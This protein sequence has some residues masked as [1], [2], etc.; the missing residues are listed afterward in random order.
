MKLKIVWLC[1]MPMLYQNRCLFF[2]I[3]FEFLQKKVEKIQL[4]GE[5]QPAVTMHGQSC[6]PRT[7]VACVCVLVGG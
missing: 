7:W 1:I 2:V 6:Y 5:T 3:Y 4:I